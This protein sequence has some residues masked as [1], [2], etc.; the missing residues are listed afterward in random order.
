[1]N[2]SAIETLYFSA[3]ILFIA[4]I[5]SHGN[6][7]FGIVIA[8]VVTLFSIF[9]TFSI[10]A[11]GGNFLFGGFVLFPGLAWFGFWLGRFFRKQQ[12]S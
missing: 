7:K 6:K 9:I 1:M 5:S 12:S 8:S 10:G 11:L 3:A 2:G 4:V